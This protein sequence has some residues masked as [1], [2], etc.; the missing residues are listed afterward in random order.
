MSTHIWAEEY[1]PTTI[2]TLILPK[3]LKE[4]FTGC[5]AK[6][7][8]NHLLFSG[9]PGMGKTSLAKLLCEESDYS[10]ILINGA[11]EGRSI[12][13]IRNSII[14]YAST[15]SM[16]GKRKAIIVD[17]ADNMPVH[18]QK[19]LLN[20]IEEYKTLRFIFTC[21]SPNNIIAPIHSRCTMTNFFIPPDEDIELQIRTTEVV[22]DILKKENVEVD[23]NLTVAK[24]VNG[25]F[26]DIRSILMTLETMSYAGSISDNVKQSVNISENPIPQ[27]IELIKNEEYRK[28]LEWI[29]VNAT[30]DVNINSFCIKIYKGLEPLLTE[31]SVAEAILILSEYLSKIDIATD[32]DIH[33]AAFIVNLAVEVEFV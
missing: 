32:P 21:N 20:I 24:L 4:I 3:H 12:D 26:P 19:A 9:G 5:I 22:L 28:M 15:V 11:N 8:F 23:D 17:E 27:L 1:R 16:T 7:D 31:K 6:Q 33:F 30:Y 2:D 13:M 18:V 10:Y 29:D 14:P 25:K